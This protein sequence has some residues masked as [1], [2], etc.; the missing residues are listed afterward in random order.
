VVLEFEARD[1]ALAAFAEHGEVA[2][3]FEHDLYDQ[4][5]LVQL[6]DWF[7]TRERGPAR[8]SLICEPE[9]LGT[10]APDRARR[11]FAARREVTP[12]QLGLARAA[13]AA[14]RSSY[15][16]R[17]ED[18]LLRETDE[19][20][21]LA[22][23]LRRHLEQFPST[24]NGL[25]RSEAQALNAI[26]TGRRTVRDAFTAA[27]HAVEDPV[28]LGD[29]VFVWYLENLATGRA[30]LLRF[31]PE[32]A[33]PLDREVS[34]TDVGEA[35]LEGVVDRVAINGIERWLG[36]VR[37]SGDEAAWRWDPSAGRLRSLL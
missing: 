32:T 19:L 18:L 8:L 4:L 3:W 22:A 7:A 1:R 12:G 28:W 6:L 34:V 24:T 33:N 2:L 16:T 10:V 26:A 30:P 11:L 36:G 25:S 31:G 5:Q 15:P 35:V 29:G 9:Y 17:I 23:A 20:P 27:N 37:L 21:F 13:W 14:F